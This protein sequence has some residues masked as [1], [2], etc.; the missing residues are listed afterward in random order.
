V[1]LHETRPDQITNRILSVSETRWKRTPTR[2]KLIELDEIH[3]HENCDSTRSHLLAKTIATDGLQHHPIIVGR[4]KNR[5]L[6]HLDGANRIA[7]LRHL[8]CRHVAAQIVDYRDDKAVSL[9]T[10]S[11][12]T[13]L[14]YSA[15]LRAA[16][17][18]SDCVMERMDPETAGARLR[19]GDLML[20]AVLEENGILG[21]RCRASIARKMEILEQFTGL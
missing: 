8:E 10:W 7:A 18:W 15:L 17:S 14:D 9:D 16:Q 12:I 13:I 20:A 11:H 3:V 19:R 21:L 5:P 6:V 1:R 2:V 4:V